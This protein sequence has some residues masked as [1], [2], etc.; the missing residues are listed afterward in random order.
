VY[1]FF[2]LLYVRIVLMDKLLNNKIADCYDN[3]KSAFL[4]LAAYA[5]GYAHSCFRYFIRTQKF[6]RDVIDN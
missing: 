6:T 4:D 5:R 3:N 1:T 2:D